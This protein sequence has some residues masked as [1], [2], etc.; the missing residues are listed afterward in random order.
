V[1]AVSVFVVTDSAADLTAEELQREQIRMVPLTVEFGREAFFDQVDLSA[2]AFWSRLAAERDLPRT[3][4]PNPEAFMDVY[5][6]LLSRGAAG[7]VSVHLSGALS[8]TLRNAEAGA[9]MVPGDI[10]I[11]DGR[12]ASLG[13]GLLA[14]WAARAARAGLNG[15][16]VAQGLEHLREHLRVYFSLATLEYLARGGRIGQAARLVGGVLDVKPIL[17]LS[18][19]SVHPLRRVRGARQV[20]AG[21]FSA[22][23]DSDLSADASV[24]ALPTSPGVD[25]TLIEEVRDRV[26]RNLAV[27]EW[28]DGTI[29]P[30]IGVH[31]GPGAFGLVVLPLAGRDLEV[32]RHGRTNQPQGGGA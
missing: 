26:S 24:V 29:G 23:A 21:L 9:R 28:R 7:V 22:L 31:A 5:T 27:E 8:G 16:E 10:R 1:G 3:A 12:S 25:P 11:V 4:A 19:G 6:A 2:D 15:A 30:V 20:A 17:T 14:I 18:G 13:T 32:W